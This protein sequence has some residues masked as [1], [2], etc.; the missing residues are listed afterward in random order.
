MKNFVRTQ[1]IHPYPMKK[2]RS[3]FAFTAIWYLNNAFID[4]A[5]SG[6]L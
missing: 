6:S 4:G 2:S 3:Q 5:L 1:K